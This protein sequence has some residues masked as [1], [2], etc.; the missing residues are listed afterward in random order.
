MSGNKRLRDAQKQRA[1]N[2]KEKKD[3][4]DKKEKQEK[5]EEQPKKRK[6]ED[7]GDDDTTAPPAK[8]T[9]TQKRN[10]R[11]RRIKKNAAE[12]KTSVEQNAT[13]R[14][15]VSGEDKV[16][17]VLPSRPAASQPYRPP[18]KLDA[19]W[20]DERKGIFKKSE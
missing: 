19:A 6:A 15:D 9:T 4:K 3:K 14:M 10:I 7:D 18:G 20:D 1:K 13:E 2:E 16:E 8:M 5:K 12:Q 17:M 11:A